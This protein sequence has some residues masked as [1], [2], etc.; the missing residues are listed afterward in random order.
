MKQFNV[1]LLHSLCWT[2][3]IKAETKEEAIE[4][5]KAMDESEL[6]QWG[7]CEVTDLFEHAED[8]DA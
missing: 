8:Q 2:V 1:T 3:P 4:K 7:E 5:V 6:Q